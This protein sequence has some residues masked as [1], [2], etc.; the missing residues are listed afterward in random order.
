MEVRVKGQVEEPKSTD[1]D[2]SRPE[3][4][5]NPGYLSLVGFFDMSSDE[6]SDKETSDKLKYIFNALYEEG[7][8]ESDILWAL[9]DIRQRLGAPRFGQKM[10]D[11]VYGYLK[12]LKAKNQLQKEINNYEARDSV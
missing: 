2:E 12:L 9:R 5:Q 6:V 3:G 10:H 1:L 7:K 4:T 11:K 8:T